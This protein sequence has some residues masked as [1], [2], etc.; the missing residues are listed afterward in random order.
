MHNSTLLSYHTQVLVGSNALSIS[1]SGAVGAGL[2]ADR[3][4]LLAQLLGTFYPHSHGV[5][6]T[7]VGASGLL[8]R[9]T[10]CLGVA[11]YGLITV[12]MA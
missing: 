1:V 12:A 7:L 3:E 9:S 2:S 11:T 4:E 8:P 6:T 10:T 5:A